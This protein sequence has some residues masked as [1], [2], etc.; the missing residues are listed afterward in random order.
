MREKEPIFNISEPSIFVMGVIL[1]VV[2]IASRFYGNL[3]EIYLNFALLPVGFE[4]PEAI[5]F[6]EYYSLASHGFLHGDWNHLLMNASGLLIFGLITFRGVRAKYGPG[7]KGF[8]FFWALVWLGVVC[9]GL[10]QQGYWLATNLNYGSAVGISGGISALFA[11]AGWVM[12]GKKRLYQFTIIF[13]LLNAA[14]VFFSPNI[15]WA[16]HVGGFIA[17]AL[18]AYFWAKPLKLKEGTSIFR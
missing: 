6:R 15:A 16:A 8:L 13:V 17:G 11:A 7:F 1:I 5:P 2:H 4:F 9:G 3:E 10:M 14:M 18:L 12:G